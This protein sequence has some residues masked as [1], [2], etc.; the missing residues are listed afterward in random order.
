MD[1]H[2]VRHVVVADDLVDV[3]L[4]GSASGNSD[5]SFSTALRLSHSETEVVNRDGRR[6]I[7][8]L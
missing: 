7:S 6:S 4:V 5:G 8:R 3:D 2:A 1:D